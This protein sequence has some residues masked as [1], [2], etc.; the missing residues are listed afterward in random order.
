MITLGSTYQR[1][2]LG[3]AFQPA[4]EILSKNEGGYVNNPLD[5]GGETYRGIA[6]NFYPNW[7]GWAYID[8]IK[9]RFGSI[10]TGAFIY[11]YAP[12]YATIDTHLVPQFYEGLWE[13]SKAGAIIN[14]QVANIYFD[15][16]VLAARAVETMQRALNMIGHNVAVDNIIG[17]ETLGAINNSDPAKLHDTF[18]KL[19]KEY[20]NE[21]VSAG[22]VD[23]SFL[24]GW[25]KRTNSF[26]SMASPDFNSKALIAVGLGATLLFGYTKIRKL[27]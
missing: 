13:R 10:P 19:R 18:K 22:K 1:T 7:A 24:P 2:T 4:F 14:Q 15:F 6:R 8:M 16:Y 25:K 17:P 9:T 20:H 26:A 5:Q 3:A 12:V 11:E 27:K 21:R 23:A